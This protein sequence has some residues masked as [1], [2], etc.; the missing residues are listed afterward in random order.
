M[1]HRT[2]NF[3]LFEYRYSNES[4]CGDSF[5][6]VMQEDAAGIIILCT[7]TMCANSLARNYRDLFNI[8]IDMLPRLIE[9]SLERTRSAARKS[10]NLVC[11]ELYKMASRGSFYIAAAS[12]LRLLPSP[13]RAGHRSSMALDKHRSNSRQENEH[14][15]VSRI[16]VPTYAALGKRRDCHCS[17]KRRALNCRIH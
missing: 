8:S 2:T 11:K 14:A 3:A 5:E 1:R 16:S 7:R 15:Q 10:S 6:C 9:D 4:T 12:A 17:P 13:P